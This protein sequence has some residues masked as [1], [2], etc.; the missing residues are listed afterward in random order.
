MLSGQPGSGR[1]I[2]WRNAAFVCQDPTCQAAA[3]AASSTCLSNEH[4]QQ[5]TNSI[6]PPQINGTPPA[7]SPP[8][9]PPAALVAT[10]MKLRL[11]LV[12]DAQGLA[13]AST[14]ATLASASRFGHF[15]SLS[16]SSMACLRQHDGVGGG[17]AEVRIPMPAPASPIPLQPR[18]LSG[19]GAVRVVSPSQ[20]FIRMIL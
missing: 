3:A 16:D 2:S 7:H 9:P 10:S 18:A 12:P 15:W 17:Y 8:E 4:I 11:S 6:L 1:S 20:S 14:E 5:L 19:D 13:E